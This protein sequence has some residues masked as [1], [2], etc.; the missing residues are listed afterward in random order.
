MKLETSYQTA[1]ELA[2]Q[3]KPV[4]YTHLAAPLLQGAGT[5]DA[6]YVVGRKYRGLF[7]ENDG[8]YVT[9]TRAASAETLVDRDS[10][11]AIPLFYST[12]RPIVSTD[13]RLLIE[14]EKPDLDV[15]AVAEYLSAS[16]LTGGK[17]I[18]RNVRSLMPD[19][20]IVVRDNVVV[21]SSKKIFR[22]SSRLQKT[23]RRSYSKVLSIIR[24]AIC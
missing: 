12:N 14:I 23:P 22:V 19:E 11:G 6:P 8:S 3:S 13:I 10:Y 18:Y 15:S 21:T 5:L 20:T 1:K 7:D 4:F 17:T 2:H 16:Y 9:V 24:S